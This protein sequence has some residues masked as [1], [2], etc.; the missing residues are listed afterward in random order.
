M[1]RCSSYPDGIL[2]YLQSQ[3]T[4][5]E[6]R[7]EPRYSVE[8]EGMER[9]WSNADGWYWTESE[10]WYELI[11]R[12]RGRRCGGKNSSWGAG[13]PSWSSDSRGPDGR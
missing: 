4:L 9:V 7:D 13:T 11:P 10:G 3:V 6:R 5:S 8:V 1:C 2:E 12:N